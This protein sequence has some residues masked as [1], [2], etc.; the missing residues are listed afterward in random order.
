MKIYLIGIGTGNEDTLTLR[1]YELIKEARF[2]VGAKRMLEVA[3]ESRA[4][5]FC[6]YDSEKIAEYFE[7]LSAEDGEY[8][9]VLLSG[10]VSFYSGAH[11]LIKSLKN[12]EVELVPG[13]SSIGYLASKLS[14][15][16][17]AARLTSIHGRDKNIIAAVRD[18]R[19]TFSLLEGLDSV[20]SICEKIQYYQMQGVKISVGCDL[21]YDTELVIEGDAKKVSEELKARGG[22]CKLFVAY[23]K[24]ENARQSVCFQIR[25]ED[26]I[27][28]TA[29]GRLVPMTKQEVRTLCL[30]KLNLQSD[31][32][33]YDIGAGTGSISIEA[34]LK[35]EDIRVFAIEK[36]SIAV[37]LLERNIRKFIADNVVPVRGQA[38]EVFDGLTAP[39]HAFIGGSAGAMKEI[40]DC[41]YSINSKVKIVITAISLDTVMAVKDYYKDKSDYNLKTTL[42]QSSQGKT[43]GENTLM[44]GENPVYIFEV[45]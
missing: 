44:L 38:S 33:L 27:R 34:A 30:A 5:T 7:N 42:V 12:H 29:E 8:G 16:Y 21:G 35:S 11:K 1:A 37:D 20:I 32:V 36:N 45:D 19:E 28:E 23:F 41:L 22:A 18:N 24:N 9:A 6:A 2:L 17:Q 10:D 40:L 14:V 15:S 26:F 25:D 3:K 31:A 4:Q 39:S 13:I 43:V